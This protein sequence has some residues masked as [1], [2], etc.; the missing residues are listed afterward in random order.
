MQQCNRQ[1][2]AHEQRHQGKSSAHEVRYK[3]PAAKHPRVKAQAIEVPHGRQS[4]RQRNNQEA[5]RREQGGQ[6]ERQ[7]RRPRS[8]HEQSHKGRGNAHGPRHKRRRSPTSSRAGGNRA[9][10]TVIARGRRAAESGGPQ[11]DTGPMGRHT[12]RMRAPTSPGARDKEAVNEGT[13]M[14]R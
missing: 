3:P 10:K 12:R 4:K 2:S 5:H 7:S 6:R 13:T 9:T 11:V 8:V 1:R 14:G